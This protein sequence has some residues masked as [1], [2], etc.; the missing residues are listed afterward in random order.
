MDLGKCENI[1]WEGKCHMWWGLVRTKQ[2]QDLSYRWRPRLLSTCFSSL[3]NFCKRRKMQRLKSAHLTSVSFTFRQVEWGENSCLKHWPS[4]FLDL[5]FTSL[6]VTHCKLTD[7]LSKCLPWL[8]FLSHRRA[9]QGFYNT[10]SIWPKVFPSVLC[11]S[12]LSD[13]SS[14]TLASYLF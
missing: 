13:S 9:V 4:E 1:N 12:Y 5:L 7:S 6:D 11:R 10:L 2:S 14:H 8:L 3:S